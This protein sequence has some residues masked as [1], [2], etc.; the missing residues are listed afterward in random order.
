MGTTFG[1]RESSIAMTF[2]SFEIS[3][4]HEYWI[5]RIS[6]SSFKLKPAYLD[7]FS[8]IVEDHRER[9]FS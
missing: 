9:L 8:L 6:N 3:T 5:R 7:P 1:S 4:G 2:A